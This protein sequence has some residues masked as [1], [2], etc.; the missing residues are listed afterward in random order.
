MDGFENTGDRSQEYFCLLFAIY[1]LL[2]TVSCLLFAIYRFLFTVSCLP[3]PL[4]PPTAPL[5]IMVGL[6]GSGKST[7]ARRYLRCH[8]DY[9]IISTDNV[10]R[11]LYGDAAIQ[12]EWRDIWQDVVQQLSEGRQAI[13]QGQA[14]GIVYDATNVRRRHRREFV[15]TA[16]RYGYAPVVAVWMDTPLDI[17]LARNQARSRQVPTEII[18]KM[19]RQ[20]MGAPPTQAEALDQVYRVEPPEDTV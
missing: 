2:F 8:P 17:C 9:R 13:A 4:V 5:L 20:L 6:P 11:Q 14:S 7:W 15:Q 18:E 10:R 1:R 19:Y 16:R 3:F 12:G